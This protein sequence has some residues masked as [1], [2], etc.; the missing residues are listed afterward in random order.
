MKLIFA[1]GDVLALMKSTLARGYV[2]ICIDE[3]NI[4]LRICSYLHWCNQYL[5]KDM[6]LLTVI[7]SI[8]A[9]EHV[10]TCV[11]EIYMCLRIIMFLH[12][13]VNW[14]FPDGMSH[15]L[16]WGRTSWN[17]PP[18]PLF[19]IY[20]DFRMRFL[21]RLEVP[22]LTGC[23]WWRLKGVGGGDGGW[24]VKEVAGKVGVAILG[25]SSW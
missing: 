25:K 8:F 11:I 18:P 3:F 6:F 19:H 22:Q 13:L 2:P 7:K 12:T 9:E 24:G 20:A 4:C 23:Q 16:F 5:L 21:I 1:W 15:T 17:Y 14:H 10:P